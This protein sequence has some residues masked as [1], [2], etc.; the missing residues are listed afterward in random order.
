[1]IQSV[2]QMV[3]TLRSTSALHK[4]SSVLFSFPYRN[5]GGILSR[6]SEILSIPPSLPES[7]F[8]CASGLNVSFM[9]LQT[10]L[11][12]FLLLC[13]SQQQELY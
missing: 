11:L 3:G 10:S 7:G 1:M 13:S 12:L 2:L 8:L 4:I 5:Q 6:P 9:T